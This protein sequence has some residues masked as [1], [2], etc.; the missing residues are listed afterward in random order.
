MKFKPT[1]SQKNPRN[2]IQVFFVAEDFERVTTA[3]RAANLS[4]AEFCRQ[5]VLFALDNADTD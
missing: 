3:A 1:T 5:A 2:S 4:K